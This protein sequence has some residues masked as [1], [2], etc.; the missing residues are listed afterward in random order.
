M[1]CPLLAAALLALLLPP[2]ARAAGLIGQVVV[3]G[4]VRLDPDSLRARLKLEQGKPYT[5]ALAEAS[6]QALNATG[7]FRDVRIERRGQDVVVTVIENPTLA[8]LSFQGNTAVE[9]TLIEPEVKLRIADPITPAKAHAAALR[10]RDLYRAK[11]RIATT[12]TPKL[13]PL[14]HNRVNLVFHVVEGAEMKVSSIGFTGNRAF[15]AKQLRDVTASSE[16]SWLDI[17]KTS[18]T[19]DAARLDLDR[20]LVLIHYRK[21]GYPDAK[22]T[23][24]EPKENT[25]R[26]GF[27]VSITIDEGDLYNF[28]PGKI[29]SGLEGID[30]AILDKLVVTTPGQPYN[31]DHVEQSVQRLSV[32]L[33]DAGQRSARVMH[34]FLRDSS[35]HTLAPVFRIQ[36]GKRVTIERINIRGNAKTKDFVIRR[37]VKQAEGDT[38]NE[39]FAARDKQR[40]QK[41]GLFKTVTVRASPGS[42]PDKAVLDIDVVE[43]DTTELSYGAGYSSSEGVIGDV[44]IADSNLFG[45][46]QH[47]RFKVSGSQTRFQADIGFT[48]PSLFDSQYA[49]GFDLLYKDIDNSK[50][51][52]YK[53]TR[54]G[55]GLRLGTA[56]SDNLSVGLNY[57]L[58]RN[59]IYDVGPLASTAIKEALTP[60]TNTGTYYTSSIGTSTTYDDRNKRTLATSGTY[61]TT[62]QDFAG[63]G[64]DARFIRNTAEGRLYYPLSDNVTLVGRAVAGNIAGWGGED[65]RLLDLFNKGGETVRGFAPGGI[66]P[67]DL[68]SANQDALGGTSFI[69]A[70]AEARFALPFVPGNIG[71]KG[72]VFTDAGSLFGVNKTAAAL[73][74]VAGASATM[75]ASVGAGLIWDSPLG[76]L[77][78]NYAVPIAS[79]PF[80]KTQPLS[81]GLVGY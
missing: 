2:S 47:L 50:A 68:A 3:D 59:Q 41:L 31:A 74:G 29:D 53:N 45:N 54:M 46:G 48:E 19:Y 8:A 17:L 38:L 71:L 32:A 70:S 23:L 52:S 76:A 57:T 35:R 28:A 1:P 27:D 65:V 26:T 10:I 51:A 81:F 60:G 56:V 37:A 64:G 49:G 34:T 43:Q 11:G 67:R 55:G 9:K 61:F 12:V 78:V 79:Q 63:V 36:E 18:S 15:T 21:N 16:S 66:G 62:A 13:E 4:S 14:P 44:Q 40:L 39:V 72:A 42:S 69:A 22:V 58:V 75:R 6:L 33:A 25:A 77:G 30:V 5:E 73:P 80:D 20:E 24:A 7:Q